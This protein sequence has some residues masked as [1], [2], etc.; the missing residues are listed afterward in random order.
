MKYIIAFVAIFLLLE[1][2]SAASI[3]VDQVSTEQHASNRTKRSYKCREFSPFEII[4][5]F[6]FCFQITQVLEQFAEIAVSLF[7]LFIVSISLSV[8]PQLLMNTAQSAKDNA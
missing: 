5:K 6:N 4:L 3:S 2:V 8:F 1:V 7:I